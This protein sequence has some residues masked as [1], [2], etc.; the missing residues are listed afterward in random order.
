[1]VAKKED[2]LAKTGKNIVIF[3]WDEQAD[4]DYLLRQIQGWS[5]QER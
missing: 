5:G 4:A 3:K 2:Y 1:M